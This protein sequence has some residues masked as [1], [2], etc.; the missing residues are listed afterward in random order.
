MEPF[1]T[2]SGVAAPILMPNVDTDSIIPKQFLQ[3]IDRNGLRDGFLHDLRF[4]QAG[5]PR[6]EFI[7]NRQPWST[8]SV[9]VVGPN[10]GC[11][12]SREHA[13]WAMQ[14][15]GIRALIGTSYGSIFRGNCFRNGVLAISLADA[16]AMEIGKQVSSAA[17]SR[18]LIDLH[19]Q[20][21]SVESTG[22][23]ISFEIELLHKHALESGED[24]VTSTMR[25]TEEIRAFESSHHHKNPWLVR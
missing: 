14:Q 6:P 25:R 24:A 22:R 11:G 5:Q 16:L 1:S 8:A 15:F 23:T 18:L 9:L 4:D 3:G 17:N 20:T 12:S 10:F 13:V 21:V 19:A 7:L 2:V